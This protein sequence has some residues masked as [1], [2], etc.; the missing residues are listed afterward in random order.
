[1]IRLYDSG[2]RLVPSEKGRK[3]ETPIGIAFSPDGAKL[4]V[5]YYDAAAVDLFDGHSLAPLPGPNL[6]GLA[7]G[8]IASKS[9]GRRMA[10]SFLREVLMMKEMA[11]PL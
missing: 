8:G 2:F 3:R 9:H 7:P 6:D 5:G 1:M 11:V 10:A 4:A